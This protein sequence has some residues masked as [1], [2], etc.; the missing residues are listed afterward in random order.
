MSQKLKILL[1][2]GK[3]TFEHNY[4][5][6]NEMLRTLLEST[7]RFEVHITEEFHGA[8]DRTL[9]DYD[10]VLINYDGKHYVTDTTD[11]FDPSAMKALLDFVDSG[12][13]AVFFHSS[14]WMDEIWPDA[15]RQLAGGYLSMKDGS[16]KNPKSDAI[17]YTKATGHPITQGA[18][19]A[20]MAVE[21]DF[22]AGVFWHPKAEIEVLATVPESIDDYV[23]VPGF[24]DRYQ[25]AN[26]DAS[27]LTDLPAMGADIPV[28][29][30]NRYGGGRVFCSTLGHSDGT[31]KRVNFLTMFV[32][33]VEWAATGAVT[34]D[35]PDRSGER[36]IW[37]WP[38]YEPGDYK[39]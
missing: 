26:K 17:V 28:M 3:V 9:K 10:A 11:I 16:R 14:L 37:P 12:K 25:P 7:G 31:I 23:N 2:T 38:F 8:T 13:G 36:R 21:D 39:G 5:M 35:F 19:K 6:I 20:W 33:G 27:S 22:F 15:Y 24:A 29:W 1:I 18:A 30:T 32:R 4:R 34:L